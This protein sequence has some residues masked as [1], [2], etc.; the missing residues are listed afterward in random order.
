[1]AGMTA[2]EQQQVNKQEQNDRVLMER[3]AER[4]R[5]KMLAE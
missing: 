3:E 5:K 4:E 2:Q 1:V